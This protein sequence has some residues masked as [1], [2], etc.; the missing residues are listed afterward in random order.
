[1]K[2]LIPALIALCIAL[3]ALARDAAVDPGK[4]GLPDKEAVATKA[5]I[6]H[7]EANPQVARDVLAEAKAQGDHKAARAALQALC[8]SL[9]AAGYAGVKAA[10]WQLEGE[11]LTAYQASMM[12]YRLGDPAAL[13]SVQRAQMDFRSYG[14][15]V[16]QQYVAGRLKAMPLA[17]REE[18][19]A[20]EYAAMV[21]DA[22]PAVGQS[23]VVAYL[24]TLLTAT[25]KALNK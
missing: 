23:N 20:G 10:G 8:N 7:M 19:L 14:F 5:N 6:E 21:L 24:E 16:Y 15:K 1:M 25:R 13:E 12:A 11:A 9:D 22:G 2:S 18:W 4:H 3:P 17:Q